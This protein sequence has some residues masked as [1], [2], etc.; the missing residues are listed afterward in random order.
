MVRLDEKMCARSKSPTKTIYCINIY[1]KYTYIIPIQ[2]RYITRIREIK[3]IG[4]VLVGLH[5]HF[6]IY[7]FILYKRGERDK[8]KRKKDHLKTPMFIYTNKSKKGTS[9][10]NSF[11]NSKFKPSIFLHLNL[12]FITQT[13][14]KTDTFFFF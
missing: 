5:F 1:H 8:E 14:F 4:M 7:F 2:I 9:P 12:K 13:D 6:R 3:D 11:K 10:N